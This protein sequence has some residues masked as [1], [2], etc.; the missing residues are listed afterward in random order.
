MRYTTQEILPSL[1]WLQAGCKSSELDGGELKVTCLA[2]V[3]IVVGKT[4]TGKLFALADKCPPTGTSLSVGGEVVGETILDPQYGTP[5]DVFSG[6]PQGE[7]CPSPPLIGGF[8]GFLMGGPQCVQTFECREE[9]LTK[10]VQVLVDTNTRKA[11][12]A[13]YW[14]G[15]LDAQG[16]NDGTYY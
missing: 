7:W 4:Q 12:E 6:V 16:K 5:F 2:G 1:S 15:L 3:D 13:N 10:E 14:K 9:F 11:Y 8:V